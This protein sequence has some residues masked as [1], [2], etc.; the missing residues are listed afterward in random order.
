MTKQLPSFLLLQIV[1]HLF[2]EN[3]TPEL[4]LHVTRLL[5]QCLRFGDLAAVLLARLQDPPVDAYNLSLL[6]DQY[7]KVLFVA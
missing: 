1:S 2:E 6:F 5:E 4:R 7:V 3:V